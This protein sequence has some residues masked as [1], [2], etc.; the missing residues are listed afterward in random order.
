MS[1]QNPPK[2]ANSVNPDG[3]SPQTPVHPTEVW[4]VQGKKNNSVFRTALNFHRENATLHPQ[5]ANVEEEHP[6]HDVKK[7]AR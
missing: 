5:T 2:S 1:Q 6:Q 4:F 3:L 7:E